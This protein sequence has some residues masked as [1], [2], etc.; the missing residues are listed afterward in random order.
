[1]VHGAT[2]SLPGMSVR[3][4]EEILDLFHKNNMG[5]SFNVTINEKPNL[6]AWRGACNLTTVNNF[7][8]MFISSDLYHEC[9]ASVCNAFYLS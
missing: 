4:E 7:D 6:A 5:G 2:A 9:G 1:M 3:L 8:K